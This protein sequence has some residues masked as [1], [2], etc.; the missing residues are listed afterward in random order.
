MHDILKSYEWAKMRELL[1][2]FKEGSTYDKALQ[3]VY[4]FDTNGLEELW[5][6]Y[7][8]TM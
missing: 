3:E 8:G 7:V 4:S 5:W 2:M 1:A 6:A